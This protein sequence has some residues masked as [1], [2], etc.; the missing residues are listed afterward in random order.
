MLK[1][2]YSLRSGKRGRGSGWPPCFKVSSQEVDASV[3]LLPSFCS[4]SPGL[5]FP[6]QSKL[7]GNARTG[8]SGSLLLGDSKSSQVGTEDGQ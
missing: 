8:Q 2:S 6:P 1:K 4:Y 7:S 5:T 3:P